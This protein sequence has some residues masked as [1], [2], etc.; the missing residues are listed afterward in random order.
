MTLR[1][2]LSRARRP[3]SMLIRPDLKR[4]DDL[5]RPAARVPPRRV[6]RTRWAVG[7]H[8]HRSSPCI[9]AC[10]VATHREC[11]PSRA[12]LLTRYEQEMPS[13]CRAERDDPGPLACRSPIFV[14]RY[15]VSSS[16]ALRAARHGAGVA[17]ASASN[18]ETA[19]HLARRGRAAT[20]A[21]ALG[22]RSRDM[23]AA[24][25]V[26]LTTPDNDIPAVDSSR[27]HYYVR[28]LSDRRTRREW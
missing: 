26:R 16:V 22:G 23:L 11:R 7:T 2:L 19:A 14:C 12:G 20:G 4:T 25:G 9:R 21:S 24:D 6:G 18:R 13:S 15:H 8:L 3:S 17:P 27:R 10:R 28:S 5:P 1:R